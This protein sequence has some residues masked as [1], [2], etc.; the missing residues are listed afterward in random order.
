MSLFPHRVSENGYILELRI[1]RSAEGRARSGEVT[2]QVGYET[3][4]PCQK[5]KLQDNRGYE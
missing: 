4:P 3:R 5:C 2:A 1:Y